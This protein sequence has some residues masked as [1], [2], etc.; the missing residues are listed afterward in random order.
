MRT[1][2]KSRGPGARIAGVL[3]VC[4]AAA[5]TI[6]CAGYRGGWESIA[7][8][9]E[10]P[11]QATARPGRPIVYEP[12]ELSAPGI[13]LR[14]TID[15]TLRTYDTQVYFFVVPL[16]VNPRDVY[17]RNVEKGRTRVFLTVTP[18]AAG[19]VFHPEAAVLSVGEQRFEGVTGYQFS[20]WDSTG[21]E[22]QTGS[23]SHRPTG[24]GFELAE[25]GR[26]YYL[27]IAFDAPV[28]S[29]QS[30]DIV[31]DV[32]RALTR[33]DGPP[34]PPIRFAPRRWKESYS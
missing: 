8:L 7:Y 16:S 34:I 5:G 4:I 30:P 13:G 32:S 33:P 21:R 26:T 3:V 29:P 28:P 1:H 19:F 15:N 27:S 11:P 20:R 24:P 2:S 12:P 18:Q 25:T 6:G 10:P 17:W 31:L 22:T 14:V 9:T 23:W